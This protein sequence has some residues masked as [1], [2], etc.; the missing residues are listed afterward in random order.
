MTAHSG[1]KYGPWHPTPVRN[2]VVDGTHYWTTIQY[3]NTT[4][5]VKKLQFII[6]PVIFLTTHLARL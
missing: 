4:K 6:V 1:G 3:Y 2:K 5:D